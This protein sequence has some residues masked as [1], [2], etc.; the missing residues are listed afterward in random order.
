MISDVWHLS[1]SL[2]N[3]GTVIDKYRCR[4]PCNPNCQFLSGRS[5]R[6]NRIH[7]I[8]SMSS[9]NSTV[10]NYNSLSSSQND[11]NV[12]QAKLLMQGILASHNQRWGMSSIKMS[13]F[14]LTGL[15][16]E[17]C[18]LLLW[19]IALWKLSAC[20]TRGF[21]LFLLK[22]KLPSTDF[23]FRSPITGHY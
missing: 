19:S 1:Y 11:C 3:T 13:L 23:L 14:N 10:Q 18:S 7:F 22:W 9:Y 21:S 17:Q 12:V 20:V 2:W 16:W 8:S 6:A 5:P 15:P 4:E